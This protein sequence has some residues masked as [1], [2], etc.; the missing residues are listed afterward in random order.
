MKTEALYYTLPEELIAQHP[1][2]KRDASRLMVVHRDSGNIEIDTY[3]NV[4]HYLQQGDCMV[5]NNTRVIRARLYG[6]KES[7]KNS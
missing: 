5:L 1:S 7:L 6:R 2:E 4:A 3:S